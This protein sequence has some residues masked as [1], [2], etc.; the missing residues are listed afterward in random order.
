ML[1]PKHR[2]QVNTSPLKHLNSEA[3]KTMLFQLHEGPVGSCSLWIES[4]HSI[5]QGSSMQKSLINLGDWPHWKSS[6]QLINWKGWVEMKWEN[7]TVFDH[8]SCH[9]LLMNLLPSKSWPRDLCATNAH[10]APYWKTK[11]R[12]NHPWKPQPGQPGAKFSRN[13]LPRNY[14]FCH[15]HGSGKWS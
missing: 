3:F 11:Q 5:C 10:N 7:S 13:P 4:D 6:I 1:T 9:F 12:R 15:N 14:S 8:I 2:R